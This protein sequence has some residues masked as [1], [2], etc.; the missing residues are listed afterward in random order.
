M[1]FHN[2]VS[3]MPAAGEPVTAAAA[4]EAFEEVGVVIDPTDL[5]VVH[6]THVAG[7]GPEPRLGIFLHTSR[8]TGE[9]ANREPE[10]CWG[11]RWFDINRLADVDLIEYPA[12]G[13]S[14]F[15]AGGAASFSEHGW[16]VPADT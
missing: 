8:W 16:R 15:L 7:S 2:A 4:R 11:V 13:I 14:A 5:R 6:V 9:P 1:T 3:A 10:K 12:V